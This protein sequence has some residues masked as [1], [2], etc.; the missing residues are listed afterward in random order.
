CHHIRKPKLDDSAKPQITSKVVES[1][2]RRYRSVIW[3]PTCD[4]F[5]KV[6]DNYWIPELRVGD[7][8]L[9]DNMGAY[10][11]SLASDF[12]G[13]ERAHIYP[14]VTAETWHSLNLSHTFNYR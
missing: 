4:S 6:L 7:W 1:S 5:D 14:V 8:L 9:L 11:V 10:S 12:N 3:G 2:E 13:F